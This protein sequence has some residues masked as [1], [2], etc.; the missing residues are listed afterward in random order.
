MNY[1]A[2]NAYIERRGNSG[3][4]EVSKQ[5]LK[6]EIDHLNTLLAKHAPDSLEHAVLSHQK[7]LV[8]RKLSLS[9]AENIQ[10]IINAMDTWNKDYPIHIGNQQTSIANMQK[11]LR[12]FPH[13]KAL[14]MEAD[15]LGITSTWERLRT[16]DMVESP[17]VN[18]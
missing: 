13:D 5:I 10:D 6:S 9:E 3:S 4:I 17:D 8:S 12:E 18:G 16:K 11:Y 1:E 2:A 7:E 15:A 14:S